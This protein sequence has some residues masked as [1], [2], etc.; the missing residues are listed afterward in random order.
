MLK[1]KKNPL[2]HPQCNKLQFRDLLRLS[3]FF[4]MRC[5]VFFRT[6]G[7]SQTTVDR[8]RRMFYMSSG[9]TSSA[10]ESP[11]SF[12]G[13]VPPHSESSEYELGDFAKRRHPSVGGGGKGG[14]SAPLA[15]DLGST[16]ADSSSLASSC[17]GAG[18]GGGSVG[19]AGVGGGDGME[20]SPNPLYQED[21]AEDAA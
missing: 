4:L 9:D 12:N 10:A 16:P 5:S 15:E 2:P 7:P 8:R 11:E 21:W 6:M 3:L 18:G 20:T 17:G 13:V 1:K 19:G 14:N